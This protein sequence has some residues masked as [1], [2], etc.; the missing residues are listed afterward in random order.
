MEAL[1]QSTGFTHPDT[2]PLTFGVVSLYQATR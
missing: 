1:L 2:T